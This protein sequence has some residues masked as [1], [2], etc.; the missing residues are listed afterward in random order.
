LMG[1][2]RARCGHPR[3]A[4]RHVAIYGRSSMRLTLFSDLFR[5]EGFFDHTFRG[6]TIYYMNVLVSL[7]LVDRKPT[8]KTRLFHGQFVYGKSI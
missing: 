8:E 4:A 7:V 1:S 2:S 5:A 6:E 3:M